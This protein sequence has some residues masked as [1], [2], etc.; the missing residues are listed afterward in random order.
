MG[1]L[2]YHGTCGIGLLDQVQTQI[3]VVKTCY[4]PSYMSNN[5]LL[6]FPLLP[7]DHL[8]KLHNASLAHLNS[9]VTEFGTFSQ[10]ASD[11]SLKSSCLMLPSTFGS[12]IHSVY[13]PDKY[14]NSIRRANCL[15]SCRRWYCVVHRTRPSLFFRIKALPLT[16]ISGDTT[17]L[18]LSWRH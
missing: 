1:G 18:L 12:F 6:P 2:L 10:S 5:P 17:I 14:S 7:E 16:P 11:V 4:V 3:P 13:E 9:L 8:W 15:I